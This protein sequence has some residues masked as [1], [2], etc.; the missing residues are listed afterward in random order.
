MPIGFDPNRIIG[1]DAM[2]GSRR[3]RNLNCQFTAAPTNRV[4]AS[5]FLS[6]IQIQRVSSVHVS[7]L[8]CRAKVRRCVSR[9]GSEYR[10][11]HLLFGN[12]QQRRLTVFPSHRS[13]QMASERNAGSSLSFLR[14]SPSTG[15]LPNS[16]V[17]VMYR[18]YKL[19]ITRP[20]CN[21]FGA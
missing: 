10:Q 14:S 20:S 19:F 12:M 18:W 17:S 6:G 11:D 7:A 1:L 9:R 4:R 5:D 15:N 21:E 2:N 16:L 3:N 8:L 13:A